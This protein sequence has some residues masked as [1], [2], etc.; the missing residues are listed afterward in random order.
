LLSIS[1]ILRCAF[2]SPQY[3]YESSVPY[4]STS[5]VLTSLNEWHVR[6][7]HNPKGYELKAH[8]PIEI[9][10][11]ERDD[12]YLSPCY[13]QRGTFLGA[14]QYRPFN[15]PVAYRST[16]STFASLISLHKGRPHWAKT[17]TLTPKV[18]KTLY[19]KFNV[20]MKVRERVDPENVLVNGYVRRHLLGQDEQGRYLDGDEG[21][22]QGETDRWEERSREWKVRKLGKDSAGEAKVVVVPKESVQMVC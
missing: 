12:I 15:L 11:T 8:F 17:H 1:L 20:F 2:Y 21:Q 9:R 14:I 16:F 10:W 5:D 13:E 4:D 6:E 7:L 18:L 22:G 3:T 19:P